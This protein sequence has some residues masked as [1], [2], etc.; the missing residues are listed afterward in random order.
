MSISLISTRNTV[1]AKVSV[2]SPSTLSQGTRL[3]AIAGQRLSEKP[4]DGIYPEL[5]GKRVLI[6]GASRGVGSAIARAFAAEGCRLVLQFR[7][8]EDTMR[9]VAEEIGGKAA[10]LRV[11]QCDF[12]D[13]GAVE[14]F[15]RTAITAFSGLD[16]VIDNA[17]IV[18]NNLPGQ[19]GPAE[20]D[21]AL[22]LML[23]TSH[24][25]SVAAAE[26]MRRTRTRGAIMHV[27]SV[28][29]GASSARFAYYAMTRSVLERMTRDQATE[30]ADAGIRVNTLSPG[31]RIGKSS[32]S[33][34]QSA[35]AESVELAEAALFLASRQQGFMNGM[36]LS[37]D[38]IDPFAEE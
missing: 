35:E 37:V 9:D 33:V 10:G 34:G 29:A 38:D 25:L 17:G 24:R 19:P 13:Q 31:L 5:A 6:T 27:T 23:E 21:D 36:S 30:W 7:A 18:A 1:P 22:A 26:E 16:I 11:F 2:R 4:H 32:I 14:R 15:T 8:G 20:L 28:P 12:R 3:S